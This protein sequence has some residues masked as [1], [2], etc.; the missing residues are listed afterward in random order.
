MR[1][2]KVK[3]SESN[4]VSKRHQFKFSYVILLYVPHFRLKLILLSVPCLLKFLCYVGVF[5]LVIKIRHISGWKCSGTR[6]PSSSFR[7]HKKV[8]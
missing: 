5:P 7:T 1:N 3:D 4:F 2:K 8:I 6:Q